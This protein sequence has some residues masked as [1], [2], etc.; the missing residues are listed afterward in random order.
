MRLSKKMKMENGTDG[1]DERDI[2]KNA[3]RKK[4]TCSE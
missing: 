4:A 1:C 2:S 3:C